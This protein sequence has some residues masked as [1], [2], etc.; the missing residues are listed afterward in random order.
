[1]S[2]AHVV[3]VHVTCEPVSPG[4]PPSGLSPGGELCTDPQ[5]TSTIE[6]ASHFDISFFLQPR[7]HHGR[8]PLPE[9]GVCAHTRRV[10]GPY[11]VASRAFPLQEWV[12]AS[13]NAAH[14]TRST[15]PP[16]CPRRPRTGPLSRRGP[17][18][19]DRDYSVSPPLRP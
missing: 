3:A 14:T 10:P 5:P 11:R 7:K 15:K 16:Q 18:D 1:M 12:M 19:A 9:L 17:V 8:T 2:L 4:A 6:K 13:A